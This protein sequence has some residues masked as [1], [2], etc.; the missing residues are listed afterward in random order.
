MSYNGTIMRYIPTIGLEIHIEPKTKSKMFCGCPNESGETQPNKNT[1]PICLG[2]PGAMPVANIEAIKSV[3]K[4]GMALE[5]K[6]ADK[7]IFDRK[8]Y[9]YPDLP[10]GYQI[11]QYEH[12]FVLGGELLGVKLRR[13]HLEEDAGK[14]VHGENG[15]TYVDFNRGGV[16]LI[17]LVTEPDVKDGDHAVRFAKELQLILR[18][19]GISNA[20]M[21]KGEMRLEANISIRPDGETKLGTKVEVK[22]L[23]SFK[24]LHDAIDFEIKRQEEAILNGER[25]IQETRGWDAIKNITFSQRSKE[26]AQDYRYLSEPD[27]PPI[28]LISGDLIDL[29]SLRI[30]IPELPESKRRRFVSEYNVTFD[31]SSLLVEDRKMAEYFEETVSEIMSEIQHDAINRAI[32]TAANYILTDLKAVL[33]NK[34]LTLEDN[35]AT[36]ENMADL[37]SMII[38]NDITSRMAKDI[39][40]D[41]V[42]T[43]MDPKMIMEKKGMKQVSDEGSILPIIKEVIT[44]NEKVV[45]DYKSGKT[46]AIQFLFGQAMKQLKG[47]GNPDVIR[48]ILEEELNNQ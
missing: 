20:D 10:K 19:L 47:Q 23:N 48:K 11:S 22:N 45:A 6:I 3:I 17:E 46:N 38:N 18:Y 16:A 21:E 39:M 5:G 24:S 13:I 37:A 9:F 44:N 4:L 15:K 14:L 1:C 32:A 7:S 40:E 12:P 31:Q 26:E 2:H 36:P 33:N 8:S 42:M 25:I 29:A 30:S 34:G 43:D 41:L 28:D 27:L 35:K